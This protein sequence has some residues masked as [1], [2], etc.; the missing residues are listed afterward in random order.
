M[1]RPK[2]V[3]LE[4]IIEIDGHKVGHTKEGLEYLIEHYKYLLTINTKTRPVNITEHMS[5]LIKKW[6][7]HLELYKNDRVTAGPSSNSR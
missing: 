4:N 5:D 7:L 3:Y 2:E 1:N 6:E